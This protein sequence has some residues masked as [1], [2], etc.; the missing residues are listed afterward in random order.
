M[1]GGLNHAL[2]L[3]MSA[4][5]DS[6]EVLGVD[7]NQTAHPIA[8]AAADNLSLSPDETEFT[9]PWASGRSRRWRPAFVDDHARLHRDRHGVRCPE[10]VLK[11][12]IGRILVGRLGQASDIARAVTFL[13]DDEAGYFAGAVLDVNGGLE[14]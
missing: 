2:Q 10:E 5:A 6:A 11:L 14:M 3:A 4:A 7:A 9:R 1:A 12:I 13:G 8:I